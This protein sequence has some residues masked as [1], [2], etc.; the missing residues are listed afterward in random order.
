[1]TEKIQISSS[2]KWEFSEL[3]YFIGEHI[4]MI[5][6]FRNRFSFNLLFCFQKLFPANWQMNGAV[7]MCGRTICKIWSFQRPKCCLIMIE[8]IELS[9]WKSIL[10]VLSLVFTW[11]VMWKDCTPP[12][13]PVYVYQL[14]ITS[15]FIDSVVK[16]K[17]W[18][19]YK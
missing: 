14:W 4:Q 8:R 18:L 5:P 19:I 15:T 10:S 17:V 6:Q 2:P 16:N 12:P 1:M 7:W 11:R 13:L 9:V 3:H